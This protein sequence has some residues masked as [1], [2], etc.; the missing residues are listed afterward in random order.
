MDFFETFF[1]EFLGKIDLFLLKL[2]LRLIAVKFF[3]N[4]EIR[5]SQTYCTG[6]GQNFERT[7]VE[8]LIFQ[9]LKVTNV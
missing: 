2:F 9:N 3:Q 4:S 8:R 1:F 6:G 7:N 5:Y